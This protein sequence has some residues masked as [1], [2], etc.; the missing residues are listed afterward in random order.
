MKLKA[1]LIFPVILFLVGCGY[2]NHGSSNEKVLSGTDTALVGIYLDEKGYPR[3][4]V[5]EIKLK[6]GQRV[7]FAGPS[8]FDI[9]F[10]DQRS[11]IDKQEIQSVNGVVIIDVPRDIFDRASR[12]NRSTVSPQNQNELIYRY[13]IRANGKVT[14]PTI[15]ITRPGE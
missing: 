15:R 1:I 3:S 12:G 5:E 7:I 8:Q 9:L 14:D 4:T 2:L 13:G 11:P 10:K 6:P